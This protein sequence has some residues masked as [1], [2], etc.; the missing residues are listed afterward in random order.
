MDKDWLQSQNGMT[1]LQAARD[2]SSKHAQDICRAKHDFLMRNP[3]RYSLLPGFAQSQTILAS[4]GIKTFIVTST[5][6]AM[7]L[8]ACQSIQELGFFMDKLVTA[9]DVLHGK[10]DPEPLRKACSILGVEP[11]DSFYVGDAYNDFASATS[12]G[13]RFVYFLSR[14]RDSRIPDE[15]PVIQDHNQILNLI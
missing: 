10:P 15:I 8:E 7:A 5:T 11:K 1:E 12:A 4:Q 9:D 14:A 3:L 6:R 2:L 13:L